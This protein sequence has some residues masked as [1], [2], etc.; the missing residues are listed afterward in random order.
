LE[1][2]QS[3]AGITKIP[4]TT[5]DDLRYFYP[6]GLLAVPVEKVAYYHLTSGTMGTPVTIGYTQADWEQSVQLMGRILNCQGLRLGELLY[7]SYG[8]GL[9]AGG[10]IAEIGAK[11]LGVRVLPVGGGRTSAAIHW[12][13]DFR[14]RAIT[15]T[16][17]F[18][19]H[20][21]ETALKE[22]VDPKKDWAALKLGIHGAETWSRGLRDKIEAAMPDGFHAYNIYGMTEAG[23]PMAAANCPVSYEESY[24]HVWADAFLFEI[25]RPETGEPVEPGEEGELVMTTLDREAAPLLRFRTRDLTAFKESPYD[26]PCG[27]RGHPLMRHIVERIDDIIKVRGTMVAPSRIEDIIS[28]IPG[29]GEMWLFVVDKEEGKMDRLII[30]FEAAPAYWENPE[31]KEALEKQVIQKVTDAIGLRVEVDVVPPDSLKRFEGKAKR[32]IDR[33]KKM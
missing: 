18:M 1:H 9:W 30:Q 16:P 7:Q 15:C 13:K 3:L 4:F 6:D 27:R 17:S 14:V 24:L 12:L 5:K 21:V 28:R 10:P 19:L 29:V 2:I 23:G 33:R 26:C 32:V 22:G 25:V 31:K 11:A 20:L 8:Y